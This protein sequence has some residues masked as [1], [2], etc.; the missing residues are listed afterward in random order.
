ML[1]PEDDGNNGEMNI[2]H[3][4]AKAGAAF[5]C[6]KNMLSNRGMSLALKLH[7]AE[8]AVFTVLL[9]AA[10]LWCLS[11]REEQRL[12]AFGHRVLRCIQ[13]LAP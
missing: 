10:E 12:D 9:Y 11:K 5:A 1:S 3:R 2:K 13:T 8:S 4:L 7:V 6:I